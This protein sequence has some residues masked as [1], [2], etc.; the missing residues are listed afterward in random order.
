MIFKKILHAFRIFFSESTNFF[1]KPIFNFSL[2][3]A[4]HF[5]HCFLIKWQDKQ[6]EFNFCS[7]H[8][9][10]LYFHKSCPSFQA[11]HTLYLRYGDDMKAFITLKKWS[12]H[13]KSSFDFRSWEH[14]W[15]QGELKL[16]YGRP[17]LVTNY[18]FNAHRT[19]CVATPWN[20][21][22]CGR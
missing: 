19:M 5:K 8:L 20:E 3:K 2:K 7:K 13:V 11:F 16:T 18:N 17:L 15:I 6:D 21:T 22:F 14:A 4:L 9:I 10:P 12:L 1:F